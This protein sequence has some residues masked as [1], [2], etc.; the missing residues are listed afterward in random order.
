MTESP[1]ELLLLKQLGATVR[2][3]NRLEQD[4]K[5]LYRKLTRLREGPRKKKASHRKRG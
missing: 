1:L 3:I 5:R 2:E 4:K